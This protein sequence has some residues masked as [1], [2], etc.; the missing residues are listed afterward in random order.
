MFVCWGVD[1]LHGWGDWGKEAGMAWQ[2]GQ[3][4]KHHLIRHIEDDLVDFFISS[5]GRP[6]PPIPKRRLV[7]G[8]IFDIFFREFAG[9]S[10]AV[11]WSR[12][13]T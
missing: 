8:L 11:Q 13:E 4:R 9:W 3:N 7:C 12:H 5:K 1:V 10:Q 6:N 2:K